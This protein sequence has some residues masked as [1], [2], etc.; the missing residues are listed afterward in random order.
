MLKWH[1]DCN[2]ERTKTQQDIAWGGSEP[3]QQLCMA[4]AFVLF[5]WPPRPLFSMCAQGFV[6]K[7]SPLTEYTREVVHSFLQRLEQ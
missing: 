5:S 6:E 2:A 3:A 4:S 7:I 1:S